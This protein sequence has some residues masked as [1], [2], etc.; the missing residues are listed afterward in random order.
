VRGDETIKT[1]RV[2]WSLLLV[3][4]YGLITSLNKKCFLKVLLLGRGDETI[5]PLGLT[6]LLTPLKKKCFKGVVPCCPYQP[7]PKAI[8]Q[9]IPSANEQTIQKC[10]GKS[11]LIRSQ[12]TTRTDQYLKFWPRLKLKPH[13]LAPL[14]QRMASNGPPQHEQEPQ[15]HHLDR[16]QQLLS[17]VHHSKAELL[18]RVYHA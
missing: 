10:I 8:M 3:G 7:S 13:A 14:H 17:K 5:K 15:Q 6:C 11:L 12:V 4:F 2:L 1:L 9:T 16:A 18:K